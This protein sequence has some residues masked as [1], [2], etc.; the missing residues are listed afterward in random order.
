[1]RSGAQLNVEP[2]REPR[3]YK[4]GI[5]GQVLSWGPCFCVAVHCPGGGS[6]GRAVAYCGVGAQLDVE[7]DREY[8]AHKF[9]S[10][11]EGDH[12]IGSGVLD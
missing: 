9:G 10:M 8:P 5:A 4:F 3:A 7:P 11:G 6:E 12:M 2:V 1:M